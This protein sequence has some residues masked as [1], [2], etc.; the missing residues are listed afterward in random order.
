[1]RHD[2]AMS[3]LSS[4]QKWAAFYAVLFFLVVAIGWVPSFK[5]TDGA[6]FGLFHLELKDDLLH[7]FSAA[8]AAFGAWRGRGAARFYFRA[9]GP[10]YFMDGVLGLFTGSGYLDA[11]IFTHGALNLPLSTRI[12][13]NL[14]HLVIGGFAIFIGYVLARA[15]HDAFR[16][17]RARA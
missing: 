2:G 6:L 10:V 13:A 1:M 3:K 15:A 17:E 5:D 16:A 8:W 9:F 4:V 11:G 7:G 12:F 14:P